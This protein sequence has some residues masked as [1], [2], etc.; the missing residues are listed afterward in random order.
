MLIHQ[1]GTQSSSS[2]SKNS[3]RRSQI[4]PAEEGE[5]NF[6]SLRRKINLKKFPFVNGETKRPA[7]LISM[8]LDH[9]LY[10]VEGIRSIPS[11]IAPIYLPKN[12]IPSKN[13]LKLVE[14]EHFPL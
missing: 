6:V 5:H 14:N 11:S 12:K 4:T 8:P 1:K 2:V 7:D 10:A 3:I 9:K 13:R